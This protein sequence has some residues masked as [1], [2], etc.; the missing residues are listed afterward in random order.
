MKLHISF[1]RVKAIRN[2]E[3]SHIQTDTN[4]NSQRPQPEPSPLHSTFFQKKPISNNSITID[5]HFRSLDT[6]GTHIRVRLHKHVTCRSPLSLAPG[7]HLYPA[8]H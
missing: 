5:E 8:V 1:K 6:I 7:T 2:F 3:P 4:S